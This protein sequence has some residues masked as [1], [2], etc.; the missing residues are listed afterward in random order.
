MNR[1]FTAL[2][3]LSAN[4]WFTGISALAGVVGIPL[5]I[6]LFFVGLAS[7]DLRLTVN[8]VPIVVV[9]SAS[10]PTV[11][12]NPN[13]SSEL[14]VTYGGKRV[15]TDV[16]AVQLALWN[17]G[18]MA[19]KPENVLQS[20]IITTGDNSPIIDASSVKIVR[21]ISGITLDS[22]EAERGILR[23]SWRILE[24]GDGAVFQIMYLGSPGISIN[25]NCIIEGQGAVTMKAST[26]RGP[27][28]DLARSLQII[29]PLFLFFCGLTLSIVGIFMG[30][31]WRYY[32]GIILAVA[33]T[34]IMIA[35]VI[36]W[37][38]PLSPFGF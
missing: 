36:L 3:K 20:L 23:V 22:R 10:F 30:R 8:S 35:G 24:R 25:G 31:R 38:N 26:I 2:K 33:G 17:A 32:L 37:R 19:I 21:E 5:S 28:I 1:L 7:R 12:T 9:N 16:T 15:T 29:S 34:S 13:T 6:L 4:P 14:I 11:I 27:Q 18:K